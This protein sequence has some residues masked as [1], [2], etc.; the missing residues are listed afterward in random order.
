MAYNKTI[1]AE[2]KESDIID[3]ISSDFD[4]FETGMSDKPFSIS[5]NYRRDDFPGRE[6][7]QQN[8]NNALNIFNH[9]GAEKIVLSRRSELTF[10]SMSGSTDMFGRLLELNPDAFCFYFSID[11]NNIFMGA[12]P[13]RLYSREGNIIKSDA[14]A[15]TRKRGK[16]NEEDKSLETELLNSG[17]DLEEHAFVLDCIARAYNQICEN[18]N[19]GAPTGV[20]KYAK[21]QHLFNEI[22]GT[23]KNNLNDYDIIKALHPTPAVGG[24][25]ARESL[26]Y[27]REI[28]QFDRGWYAGPIGWLSRDAAEFAVG[29][30]SGIYKKD[31]LL[32]YSGAGIV[33]GSRPIEEWNEIN[34]KLNNFLRI[35]DNDN[36]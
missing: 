20:R 33:K 14:L 24:I 26:R 3:A 19:I 27:I 9:G 25:P 8:I 36:K 12:S 31:R 1:G 29:I 10:K 28:E 34:N 23:L 35:F 16:T 7:W 18:R 5:N 15:G 30:R 13:E 21:V 6:A 32:L 17:K 4:L 11:D 22:K 2:D